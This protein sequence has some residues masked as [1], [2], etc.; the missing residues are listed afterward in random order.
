MYFFSR[1]FFVVMIVS[2]SVALGGCRD[3]TD[4]APNEASRN[5]DTPSEDAVAQPDRGPIPVSGA[6]ADSTPERQ[7]VNNTSGSSE[8][9]D[10]EFAQPRMPVAQESDDEEFKPI[11]LQPLVRQPL[12]KVAVPESSVGLSEEAAGIAKDL[13]ERFSNS[14]DALEVKARIHLLLGETEQARKA[15]ESALNIAPEYAYAKLGLGGLFALSGEYEKAVELLSDAQKGMV[16][17]PEA[18]H[19]LADAY[20]KLGNNNESLKVLKAQAELRPENAETHMLIGQAHLL[21]K[22]YASAKVSFETALSL[23][24]EMP[25]AMDGLAKSLL[26]LGDRAKAKELLA[27]EREA[28]KKLKETQETEAIFRAEQIDYAPR[29]IAAARIYKSAGKY[30][31]EAMQLAKKAC[32]LS[33]NNLAAWTFQLDLHRQVSDTKAA[34]EVARAM[35]NANKSEPSCFFT[36]AVLQ[37]TVGDLRGAEKS[38]SRVIEL[39]PESAA[40]YESLMRLMISNGQAGDQLINLGEKLVELR[41]NAASNELAAQ[42][43]AISGKY[44]RAAELLGRAIELEPDNALYQN[45]LK[46]LERFR[47]QK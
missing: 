44:D 46:Q 43:C 1:F 37:Q 42:A 14:P 29:Y 22:D 9:S 24:A 12:V 13:G 31:A 41:P 4:S 30:E 3:S 17:L 18:A 40:G 39:A 15:W 28:R 5:P 19:A 33:P 23:E 25:K 34:V 7:D 8:L 47:A 21:E 20:L 35:C 6:E 27:Q 11:Q 36:L 32:L 26:R 38:Y 16:G 10:K 45:A 2:F